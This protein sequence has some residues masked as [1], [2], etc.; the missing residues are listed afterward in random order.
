MGEEID[1]D[2]IEYC[3]RMFQVR[4]PP[5]PFLFMRA[6]R[7]A[8]GAGGGARGRRRRCCEDQ[9]DDESEGDG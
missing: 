2:H 7:T 4:C 6:G 1:S 9:Q 8:D 3:S 5:R